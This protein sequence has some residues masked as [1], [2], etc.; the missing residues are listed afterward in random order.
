MKDMEHRREQSVLQLVD[1][2]SYINPSES[3]LKICSLCIGKIWM[4]VVEACFLAK[5]ARR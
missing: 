5:R 4:Q 3:L 2:S 1:I